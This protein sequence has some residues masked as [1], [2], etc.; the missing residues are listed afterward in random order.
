M[1]YTEQ[2]DIL[3]KECL[4][5]EDTYQQI[6]EFIME[7]F[8]IYRSSASVQQRVSRLHL[9]SKLN[10]KLTTEEYLKKTKRKKYRNTR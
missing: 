1:K 2:E 5:L 7:D 10:K 9:S 4:E 8:G 3:I 6:S